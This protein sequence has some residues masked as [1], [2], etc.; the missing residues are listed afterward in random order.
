MY[1]LQTYYTEMQNFVLV[2][3]KWLSLQVSRQDKPSCGWISFT[4]FLSLS[5]SLPHTHV[6]AD[7]FLSSLYLSQTHILTQ[8]HLH[9]V[10][11]PYC[12]RSH[13]LFFAFDPI[14]FIY[15][16]SLSHPI[17]LIPTH[18]SFVPTSSYRFFLHISL[19]LLCFLLHLMHYGLFFLHPF[20]LFPMPSI[21]HQSLTP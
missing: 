14:Y 8:S 9:S 1:T 7:P 6:A 15:V 12:P 4:C 16:P 11:P 19:N 18:T 21:F 10:T 2:A 17:T 20:F 3:D 13:T 5:A